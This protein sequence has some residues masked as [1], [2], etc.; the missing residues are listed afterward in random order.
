MPKTRSGKE[1]KVEDFGATAKNQ[2]MLK[3]TDPTI[4]QSGEVRQEVMAA[5]KTLRG[6]KKWRE[7]REAGKNLNKSPA[8][9]NAEESI[10]TKLAKP[11]ITNTGNL[12]K[13][14]FE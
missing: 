13:K 2:S 5:S 6:V 3:A 4:Q 1:V 12:K 9:Y 14:S 8:R 7:D 11:K 10:Q